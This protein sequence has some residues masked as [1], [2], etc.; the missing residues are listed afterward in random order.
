MPN[1]EDNSKVDTSNGEAMDAP[2]SLVADLDFVDEFKSGR[3]VLRNFEGILALGVL[4][5]C[6]YLFR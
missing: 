3:G 5:V 4:V 6:L 2:V 1:I